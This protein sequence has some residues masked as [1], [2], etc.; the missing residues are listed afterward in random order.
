MTHDDLVKRAER[1]LKNTIHCRVVLCELVAYTRT[2]EVPDVIGW[3]GGKSILV[4]AKTS[5]ADFLADQKKHFRYYHDTGLG[6]WR[7]YLTPPD[8]IRVDEIPGS[9]GVYE[10]QGKTIRHLGGA[11]YANASAAPFKSCKDSEVALLISALAR[12]AG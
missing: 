8:L 11:K 6:D 5:R 9:W 7:F 2:G 1:W 4:E 3:V 10:V 12:G